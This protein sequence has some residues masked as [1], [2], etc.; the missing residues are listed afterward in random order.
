MDYLPTTVVRMDFRLYNVQTVA[1]TFQTPCI[2]IPYYQQWLFLSDSFT[3]SHLQ[4]Y[5]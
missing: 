5:R 3:A 4:L 2:L 1:G